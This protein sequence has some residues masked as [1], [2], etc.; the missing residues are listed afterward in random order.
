MCAF[1][2]QVTQSVGQAFQVQVPGGLW[3]QQS[4]WNLGAKWSPFPSPAPPAHWSHSFWSEER[5]NAAESLVSRDGKNG[6]KE[7]TW[8][9]EKTLLSFW[10]LF[11]CLWNWY[12]LPV[13]SQWDWG[14]E[15]NCLAL[16]WLWA[17][18]FH[19]PDSCV[20]STGGTDRA[21]SKIMIHLFTS[22]PGGENESFFWDCSLGLL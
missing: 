8:I 14:G 15:S 6:R 21:C 13:C 10:V 3:A 1:Q 18:A 12:V 9:W 20:Q 4:R 5:G 7:L 11:S 17:I 16:E 19:Q 2:G 22:C